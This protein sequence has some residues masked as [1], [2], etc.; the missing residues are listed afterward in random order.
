V[1]RI[2]LGRLYPYPKKP[3]NQSLTE[4]QALQQIAASAKT[5]IRI[6]DGDCPG[7]RIMIRKGGG[8]TFHAQYRVAGRNRRPMIML[9]SPP[10][11]SLDEARD[12][13]RTIIELARKGI[14]VADGLH[15]RLMRELK[16]QGTAW[17]A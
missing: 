2:N 3:V 8:Y 16:A 9:G 10:E 12:L 6:S 17:R 4:D 11:M 13:T 5:V 15:K 7:L 1:V 14:D